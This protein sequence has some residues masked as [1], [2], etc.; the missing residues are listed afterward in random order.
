MRYAR[1]L[2]L[3]VLLALCASS[4]GHADTSAV[5]PV[6]AS[7]EQQ[8][9]LEGWVKKMVSG[10]TDPGTQGT[11]I[12]FPSTMAF[13]DA[14]GNLTD[15][16]GGGAGNAGGLYSPTWYAVFMVASTSGRAYKIESQAT[17][18]AGVSGSAVGHNLDTSFVLT[19]EHNPADEWVWAG[20]GSAPQ[21]PDPNPGA[22]PGDQTLAIGTH[23]IYNSGTGGAS[24]II[25]AMYSLPPYPD[26][27]DPPA[28]TARPSG[29]DI[30]DPSKPEGNYEGTVTISLTL[31]GA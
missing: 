19:P 5:F 15:E 14:S 27:S 25:R 26:P 6:T 30:V 22:D 4:T 31:T 23:E 13:G 20:G 28:I 16:L 3:V 8:L 18:F 29:W 21:G 1:L 9:K 24:R 2:A 10:E 17:S 12:P 11:E 7:I